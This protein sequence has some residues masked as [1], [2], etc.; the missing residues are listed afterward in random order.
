MDFNSMNSKLKKFAGEASTFTEEKLGT[1]E[2]TELDAHFENLMV[3]SEKTK[4]WTE[5]IKRSTEAL[6]QPNP[7]QRMEDFLYEKLDKRKKDR[8]TQYEVLGNHMV[9]AGNDFG[10]G[11]S[12]VYM[13]RIGAEA[14]LRSAQ[15]EFDRQAEITKILLEGI[16]STHAHHLRCLNDFIEAQTKFFAQCQQYMTDLQRQ[17]GR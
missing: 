2:K 3:R 4:L 7:N 9:D 12:Y 14:D 5:Q 15:S 16:N 8:M 13:Y 17:L 1:A 10:P 11:T 6:I